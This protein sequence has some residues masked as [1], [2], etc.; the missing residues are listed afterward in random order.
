MP[1]Y[2]LRAVVLRKHKLG[3]ADLILTLLAEDGRQV[4]AV[5]K[6]VRKTKSRFGA[7]VEPLSVV[8]A[9]MHTGRSLDVVVEA[10]P[11]SPHARLRGD[12]DRY[13]A[14][15]VVADVLQKVTSE[16]DEQPVLFE[17]TVKTL[18]VLETV[19]PTALPALLT[20]FLV[21][22][23]GM[24]GL[25]PS[26]RRC[27]VC[28]CEASAGMVFSPEAGGVVC[29]AC[30]GLEG[31]VAVGCEAREALEAL[32]R[33]RLDEVEDLGLDPRAVEQAGSLM[34][35]FVRHHVHARLRSLEVL[36]SLE[37]VGQWPAP[38]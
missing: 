2:H 6:G 13:A 35:S 14:A 32:L 28:A 34:R 37:A 3:E 36:A 10:E 20:A 30:G 26:L 23:S 12:F 1:S 8:S 7:R 16:G 4:R 19:P 21:K 38:E 24:I 18:D 22:V 5:A 15:S 33:A 9:L 11:L 31:G 29:P 25:M 17:L 27:A